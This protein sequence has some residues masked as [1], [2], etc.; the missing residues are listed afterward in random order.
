MNTAV[1]RKIVG[2]ILTGKG[3]VRF[4]N[5]W[6]ISSD[7]VRWIINLD[8]PPAAGLPNLDLQYGITFDVDSAEMRANYQPIYCPSVDQIGAISNPRKLRQ[9]LALSQQC[10]D[11]ERTQVI[12]T[13]VQ[14]AADFALAHLTRD[15][16]VDAYRKGVFNNVFV[17]RGYKQLLQ[18]AAD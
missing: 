7:A 3:F 9:C 14:E 13:G 5:C 4:K 2:E 15:S 17:S 11:E 16:V 6:A 12:A 8:V 10:A 1:V 18:N